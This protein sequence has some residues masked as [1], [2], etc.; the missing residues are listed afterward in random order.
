MTNHFQRV[1]ETLGTQNHASRKEGGYPKLFMVDCPLLTFTY[2]GLDCQMTRLGRRR[3]LPF[4]LADWSLGAPQKQKEERIQVLAAGANRQIQLNPNKTSHPLLHWRKKTRSLSAAQKKT[5][6]R[7]SA[8]KMA[9]RFSSS[10][11]GGPQR[12]KHKKWPS[13]RGRTFSTPS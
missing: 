4:I 13:G 8:E 11:E 12:S 5:T 7:R 3:G 1:M 2:P 6:A 9:R 10:K